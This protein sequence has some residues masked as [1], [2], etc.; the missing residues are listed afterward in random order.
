[1]HKKKSAWI[2]VLEPG[3]QCSYLTLIAHDLVDFVPWFTPGKM[4]AI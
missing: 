4:Q 2:T 3:T 1:M